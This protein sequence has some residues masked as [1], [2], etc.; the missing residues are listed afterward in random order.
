MRLKEK[1]TLRQVGK[2]Y[3]IVEPEKGMVD[4]TKVFSLNESASWLWKQLEGID[5]SEQ[6]V[7]DLLL[8][9]Y[10]VQRERATDDARQWIDFLQSKGLLSPE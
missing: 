4:M 9:R 10:D 2:D 3:V 8:E 1:L 5:F 7:A 6:S